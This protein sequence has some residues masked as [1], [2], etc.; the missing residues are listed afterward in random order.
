LLQIMEGMTT[1]EQ[2]Q[3]LKHSSAPAPIWVEWNGQAAPGGAYL[4]LTCPECLRAF[5]QLSMETALPVH[6]AKCIYCDSAFDYAIVQ[7]TE[8]VLRVGRRQKQAI[9]PL[10]IPPERQAQ[11]IFA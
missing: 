3:S 10:P 6:E 1:A 4:M 9:P 8:P 2:P 5:R 11:D 7:L